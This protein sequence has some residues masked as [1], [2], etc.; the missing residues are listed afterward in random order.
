MT[1][2]MFNVIPRSVKLN[3]CFR[4][5]DR[6]SFIISIIG[7]CNTVGRLIVG[8]FVDLPWVSSLVVT[9]CSLVMPSFPEL[10]WTSCL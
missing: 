1:S 3:I 6:A 10:A 5:S 7:I 2:H 8:A 4:W 9:N